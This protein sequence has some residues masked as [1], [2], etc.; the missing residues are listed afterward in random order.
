MPKLNQKKELVGIGDVQTYV[1]RP[2]ILSRQESYICA[3]LC[4]WRLK[5]KLITFSI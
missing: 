1:Y 5:T 2:I 3:H 4:V